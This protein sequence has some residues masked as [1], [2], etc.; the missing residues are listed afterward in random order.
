[1]S[2]PVLAIAGCDKAA[3]YCWSRAL[4]CL[5]IIYTCLSKTADICHV[6]AAD[7]CPVC[8]SSRHN[9]CQPQL[10][11]SPLRQDRCLWFRWDRCL[12]LREDR[13]VLLRQ[14]RCPLGVS[15]G[16]DISSFQ[17]A[18]ICPL[19]IVHNVE[20]LQNGPKCLVN[21]RETSRTEPFRPVPR[22]TPKE[23]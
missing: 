9:R 22:P 1:M 19:L 7:F 6:S 4:S 16:Q 2:F 3:V 10:S 18:R 12:Q 15:S 20:A 5:H 11:C 13:C 21:G 17:S 14:D 8:F 23:I